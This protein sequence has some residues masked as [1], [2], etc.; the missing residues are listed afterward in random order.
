MFTHVPL[1]VAVFFK[2][3]HQQS[4]YFLANFPSAPASLLTPLVK[5][6]TFTGLKLESQL[7]FTYY[8]GSSAQDLKEFLDILGNKVFCLFCQ[9]LDEKIT[10]CTSVQQSYSQ[11][12]ASLI[13]LV[14]IEK[15]TEVAVCCFSIKVGKLTSLYPSY[16]FSCKT[17]E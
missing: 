12:L 1:Y 7:G 11:Q 2:S 13:E 10:T 16:L 17:K 14:T 15:L 6:K 3:P 5:L 9:E 4:G 8:C